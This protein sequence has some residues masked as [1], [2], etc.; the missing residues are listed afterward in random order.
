MTN[1]CLQQDSDDPLAHIHFTAEGEVTFKSILFVPTS[2]PRGLFDEYGSKK[3]DYIKVG[4]AS[5]CCPQ[6]GGCKVTHRC[7]RF[8]I[9]HLFL[10]QLFVRRVFITDDFNDMMPK[11]LNFVK[12]VVSVFTCAPLQLF[13]SDIHCNVNLFVG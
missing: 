8:L 11:Y 10:S 1:I 6:L 4:L 5:F 7:P 12:G 3:N 9:R 2:A 13:F